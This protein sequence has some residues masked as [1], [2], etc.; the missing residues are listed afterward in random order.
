MDSRDFLFPLKR[1]A[2]LKLS[3]LQVSKNQPETAWYLLA[4]STKERFTAR[5]RSTLAPNRETKGNLR[6]SLVSLNP[7]YQHQRN[8]RFPKEK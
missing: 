4:P 8:S 6:L 7:F 1:I 5:R 2:S 3:S